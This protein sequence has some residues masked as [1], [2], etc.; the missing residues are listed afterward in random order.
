MDH[1]GIAKILLYNTTCKGDGAQTRLS[2]A[3][4]PSSAATFGQDAFIG[5]ASRR[6]FLSAFPRFTFEA[7]HL[8]PATKSLFNITRTTMS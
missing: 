5:L 6:R 1:E 4:R 3:A 2:C 8:G 7:T